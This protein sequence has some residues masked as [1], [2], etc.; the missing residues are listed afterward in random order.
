LK[1]KNGKIWPLL[2]EHIG[3]LLNQ[4]T[5]EIKRK[6]KKIVD[7]DWLIFAIVEA[8]LVATKTGVFLT[9]P[10]LSRILFGSSI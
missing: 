9:V 4:T 2:G 8:K 3:P 7:H 6:W 10:T 1:Y 5:K